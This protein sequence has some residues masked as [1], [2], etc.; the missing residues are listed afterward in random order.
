[1]TDWPGTEDKGASTEQ[2]PGAPDSAATPAAPKPNTTS[3]AGQF[4]RGLADPLYGGVQVAA[5]LADSP[6]A[7]MVPGFGALRAASNLAS[8]FDLIPSITGAARKYADKVVKDR[9]EQI[10]KER[11]DDASKTDWWR[12]GGNVAS[13]LPMGAGGLLEGAGSGL[14]SM[15]GRGAA[16]GALAGALEPVKDGDNFGM[17]KAAQIGEGGVLGGGLGA[18][19]KVVAKGAEAAGQ[20]VLRSHPEAAEN[21]AVQTILKRWGQDSKHG[22]GT[23]TE[24]L[25]LINATNKPMALADVA[26]SNVRALGGSVARA[27]GESQQV[28]KKFLID[29]DK[30]AAERLTKDISDYVYSGPTA[31]QTVNALLHARSAASTPLYQDARAL[32]KVWSPRLDEFFSHPLIQQGLARGTKLEQTFAL[33]ENREMSTTQMGI[34]L[35]IDGNVKMVDKPSLAL[36]DM[37]KRGL[38]AIV[39]DNRDT[40]GRLSVDG[41]AASDLRNAFVKEIDSLDKDGLYR[42]ARN[43]WAGYSASKD[44][45]QLGQKLMSETRSAEENAEAIAGM[46]EGDKEFLRLGLADSMRAKIQQFTKLTGDL[47]GVEPLINSQGVINAIRPAFKSREELD[48]F[49]KAVMDEHAMKSSRQGYLGG[50]QSQERLS[51]EAG[52]LPDALGKAKEFLTSGLFK[53]AAMAWDLYSKIGQAPPAKIRE[54][55]AKILFKENL[56]PASQVGQKLQG[57]LPTAQPNPN[58]AISANIS[59]IAPTLGAPATEVAP[60]P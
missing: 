53:K 24:A 13:A 30:G 25:D 11:G 56:Q 34:S 27:P 49:V 16:T 1:M 15:V 33:A 12:M 36:L 52:G 44:A 18:G 28:A 8:G 7:N 55:I 54:E 42:K 50:S 9:E 4:G 47:K 46:S 22:G 31:H 41:K 35:D 3:S 14:L 5:H 39:A 19:G 51:E 43:T 60:S 26:G 59:R 6:L 21:A 45:V 20:Y 23:A 48:K 37:A 57:K 40:F 38:D 2:W 29:R 17:T 32:Q 58:Q 10:A